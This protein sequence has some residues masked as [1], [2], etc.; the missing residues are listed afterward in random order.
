MTGAGGQDLPIN[1]VRFGD[2]PGAFLL[3]GKL[4][5]LL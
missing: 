3:P 1:R 5:G 2:A 4:I